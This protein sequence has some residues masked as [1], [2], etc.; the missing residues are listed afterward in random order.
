MSTTRIFIFLVLAL[1]LSGC[2]TEFSW[3]RTIIG[4]TAQYG[5]L[6]EHEE[7][8]IRERGETT[9]G[10]YHLCNSYLSLR[11]FN[12]LFS[13]LDR[14]ETR[15]KGGD[16]TIVYTNW[17]S[18]TDAMPALNLMRAEAGLE[19]GDYKKA[20]GHAEQAFANLEGF[21]S[22]FLGNEE[23]MYGIQ[24]LELMA[25]AKMLD[26]DREQALVQLKRLE[27]YDIGIAG[28]GITS[29]RRSGALAK[30]NLALGRYDQA[31]KHIEDG[32]GGWV[33]IGSV[34]GLGTLN[35]VEIPYKFMK[36]KAYMENGR[37]SQAKSLYD[38]LLGFYQ[39]KDSNALYRLAL[40]D[41]GRIAEAE[42]DLNGAIDFYRRA[43][44]VIEQQRSTLNNEASKIGFV[45]DK[46]AA[47]KRLVALLVRAQRYAEAF[48]YL[49]RSKARALVDML[50]AKKDFAVRD[51]DEGRMG[52]LLAQ[53]EQSE[54]QGF[55]QSAEPAA[56]DSAAAAKPSG[57]R[58]LAVSAVRRQIAEAAPEVASLVSVSSTPLAEIQ[59]RIPADEM[60][61][62]Y[63]YD[64]RSLFV[65]LLSR[66]G[67][68][69]VQAEVGD[70]E[71]QAKAL[72]DAVAAPSSGAWQPISQRLYR[73]LVGPLEPLL[74]GYSRL[75]IVP[76][77]VLHYVPFAALHDGNRYLIDK[78]A[79]RMLPSA[80]VV[81]YL[82]D[83]PANKSG[84]ILAFG[85]PD[86]GDPRYDLKF[87][88]EEARTIVQTVGGSRAVLRK[89]ANETTL[90]K[91]AASFNYLHFATHGE[92]NA[93]APLNSALLLAKDAS[94]DG[95]LTVGKLYSMRLDIDLATLS[96]CETGLGKIANGDDVVGLT[97]GF[98]FAGA[99]TVVASLWQV[100]DRA[101]SD[102]M[103]QFYQGLQN[104]DKR[105]ALRQAQISAREKYGHPYYW[106]AFQLTGN[107]R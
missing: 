65:F 14:M 21:S 30:V 32:S 100:D 93:D 90:R 47:Y 41:R 3:Q 80:S 67:L 76:H 97:R 88:E 43:V 11:D 69:V 66:Q 55:A 89:E 68:R 71:A 57:Q 72:R 75:V 46:Q 94:S 50:A 99:S 8:Q 95:L 23:A 64:D 25:L 70:L 34:I 20:F 102:L 96:A 98:L 106:A 56:Q 38:S 74:A 48:D 1:A 92:F 35:Y 61:V 6:A 29:P 5:D 28:R 77:G 4:S 10:L 63:H 58:S 7:Q 60:L 103:R 73:Q 39:I 79:F 104:G 22:S 62:E 15:I 91:N 31:L 40:F 16:R 49:E 85:N 54:I 51:G 18:E 59:A 13:C 2:A 44:E 107:S 33:A 78:Y 37:Q 105:E 27:N 52:Q 9:A 17:I 24:A 19:L 12:K 81:K 45:G 36:A 82:R 42:G 101:T 86:L 53:A 84:G 26:G 87:A 83:K